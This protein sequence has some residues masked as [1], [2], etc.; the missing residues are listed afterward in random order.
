M[1]AVFFLFA[2][3]IPFVTS[4]MTFSYTDRE[5][6]R[7]TR[8][9]HYKFLLMDGKIEQGDYRRL[10]N[11]LRNDMDSF[12]KSRQIIL[13]SR[14]GNV[15]EAMHI[16]NFVRQT[17]SV[18]SVGPYYGSCA[19]S[20]FLILASAPLRNW[21]ANSVGIHRP[22]LEAGF[23]DGK[24]AT[25]SISTQDL[26]MDEV[27]DYLV[28]L[29]VPTS[30]IETMLSTPSDD[31]LWLGE[32]N[33]IF[34]RYSPSYEQ[35]LVTKCGLDLELERKMFDGE[36]RLVSDVLKA[37]ECAQEFT[38]EEGMNFFVSELGG[39]PPFKR[40]TQEKQ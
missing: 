39:T 31:V 25:D 15:L 34:G 35:V 36:K 20:C 28:K 17:Y 16:G 4:A 3:V 26:L 37:R 33:R 21:Q 11:F 22:Y 27:H 23:M 10:L 14:G 30:Y 5:P 29:R 9:P 38:F 19:S 12:I 13:T 8:V 40:A 18:V 1:R 2:M 7:G 24:S 32:P 6:I